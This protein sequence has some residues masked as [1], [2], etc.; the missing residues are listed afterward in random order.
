[1]R[2]QQLRQP[3]DIVRSED[4]IHK[5]IAFFDFLYDLRL[6]HHA[7]AQRHNHLRILFF[8][9]FLISQTAVNLLVCIITDRTGIV[10]YKIRCLFLNDLISDLLQNSPQLFRVSCIH[11]AAEI[12]YGSR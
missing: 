11:L 2:I 12:Y 8:K 10:Q 5:S 3:V 1:M 4:N 6:L 9:C 7:A